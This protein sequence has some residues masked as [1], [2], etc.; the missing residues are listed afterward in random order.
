ME[1]INM[2]LARIRLT[3]LTTS[4]SGPSNTS[5]TVDLINL[6]AVL[7]IKTSLNLP[8]PPLTKIKWCL[9]RLKRTT[10]K[11]KSLRKLK[12]RK[13]LKIKSRRKNRKKNKM[14]RLKIKN[15]TPMT[16]KNRKK[17]QRKNL[18]LL[19]T[20]RIKNPIIKGKRPPKRNLPRRKT[21]NLISNWRILYFPWWEKSRIWR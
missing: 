14:K 19:P 3:P 4:K 1:W 9:K 5:K 2:I 12:R 10:P 20:R 18:T 7:W 21:N 11:K 13:P 16:A 15:K 6:G 8:K 17:N